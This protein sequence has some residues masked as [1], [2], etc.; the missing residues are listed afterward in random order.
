MAKQGSGLSLEDLIAGQKRLE[1]SQKAADKTQERISI[2]QLKELAQANKIAG[3]DKAMQAIQTIESVKSE[4]DETETVEK[5]KKGL[6]DKDGDGA[7]A[8]IIKML[9]AINKSNKLLE[10]QAKSQSITDKASG[11]STYK[12]MGDRI[13]GIK[14]SFKDFFTARGFL[15]KT[16]IAKRGGTGLLSQMADASEQKRKQIDMYSKST[17]VD[18]ST[19]KDIIEES[20]KNIKE[21]KRIDS[22]ISEYKQAGLQPPKELLAQRE[23]ISKKLSERDVR[24]QD[25]EDTDED[26]MSESEIEQAKT[27]EE[28]S[29]LLSKIEENTRTPK[30]EQAKPTDDKESKGGLLSGL[31]GGMKGVGGA[32]SGAAKGLLALAG[33]VWIISKAM[34]NFASVKIGDFLMGVGAIAALTF[35][36]SKLKDSDASK[37]LLGLGA[38]LWIT[39][40]AFENF[41]NISFGDF[42]MGVGAIAALTI[43]VK[44]LDGTTGGVVA[45]L[46]LGAAVWVVSKAFENFAALSW[47]DM[48]K[49]ITV[50]GLLG[51]GLALLSPLAIP[52]GI[53]SAAFLVFGAALWV[54]SKAFENIA[55]SFPAFTEGL[56]KLADIGGGEL[57][58][59]AAGIVAIGAAMAV[60]GASQM[61]AA[62][63]NLVTKFLSLG[64]DTPVEQLVKI[65]EA[66]PGIEKAATGLERLA[67]AMKAFGDVDEDALDAAVEAAEDI[68]DAFDDKNVT[69]NL[70]GSGSTQPAAAAAPA[71]Q[72]TAATPVKKAPMTNPSP[73]VSSDSE[74]VSGELKG[75][76]GEQIKG[77]P[78]YKKHYD[79]AIKEGASPIEA[80]KDAIDSV[81]ADMVKEQQVNPQQVTPSAPAANN[82]YGKS[83][84]VAAGDKQVP[85]TK[86]T[87]VVNAPTQVNNQTQNAMFKKPVRNEDNTLSS[88][89]KNKFS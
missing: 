32:L 25:K 53:I 62:L 39:S 10:Q 72:S 3:Q 35:A 7:N 66:G 19:A 41:A 67:A 33:A 21:S 63:E 4:K 23:D 46:A 2:E 24:F 71:Q 26:D 60:F 45:L 73:T 36:A 64:D 52:I 13:A 22:E 27:N 51:V 18:K 77:H 42:L 14:D 57:I 88:W 29:E 9:K 48:L 75:V 65:G 68:A 79:Q 11:A 40:K 85:L 69:I 49:G 55:E 30:A 37:T 70:T 56:Q 78:N 16:G 6:I 87:N 59:V 12:T 15:D 54:I 47:S 74:S 50:I 81:K 20:N 28:Q 82:I 76:T 86:S 43:A 83:A 44:A 89:L 61:V 58:A 80:A 8:N 38:A 84:E 5:L 17:G 31:M 34:Q 1:E